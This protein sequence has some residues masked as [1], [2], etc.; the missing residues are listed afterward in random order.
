MT[1]VEPVEQVKIGE[2][3]IINT[4]EPFRTWLTGKSGVGRHQDMGTRGQCLSEA[5]HGLWSATTMQDENGTTAPSFVD[6]HGQAVGE[7]LSSSSGRRRGYSAHVIHPFWSIHLQS[8][9]CILVSRRR[10]IAKLLSLI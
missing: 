1:Q 10:A 5:R 2:S 7:G 6:A 8:Q 9:F 3:E 4:V